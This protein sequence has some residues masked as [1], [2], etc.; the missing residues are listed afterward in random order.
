VRYP[1]RW[2]VLAGVLVAV[3]V[4]LGFALVHAASRRAPV[5]AKPRASP[6]ASRAPSAST[7]PAAPM[8]AEYAVR[9]KWPGGFN[10]ELALTNLGSEPV[11][12]WT[13][14][15]GLPADVKVDQAWSADVTRVAGAVLLRS[16][17][18]NTYL[19]PGDTVRMGFAATGKA[20]APSSC[21]VNGSP[22]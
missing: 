8:K 9:G 2:H 16:Q 6:S 10:A 7:S 17:P 21:T 11:E 22:C 5:Q 12:G 1:K 3:V 19:G 14:R 18:W 13:V 4:L 15:L 20:S